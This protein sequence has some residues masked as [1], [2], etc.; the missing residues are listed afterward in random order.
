M[1][2]CIKFSYYLYLFQDLKH[3]YRAIKFAEWCVDYK[4]ELE[5]YPPDRPLSLYEGI[6]GP[7]YLLLDI[8]NPM[9]AKFPGFTL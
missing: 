8:Q 5:E 6:A 7:T 3:L 2:K 4:K 9:T 1:L